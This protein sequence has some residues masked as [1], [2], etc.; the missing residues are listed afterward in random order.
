MT[1][2]SQ[3]TDYAAFAAQSLQSIQL[4]KYATADQRIATAGIY[5]VTYGLLDLAAAIREH[6]SR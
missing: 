1:D 4:P 3:A 5:A 6:A 2:N